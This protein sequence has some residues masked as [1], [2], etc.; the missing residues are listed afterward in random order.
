MASL[1]TTLRALRGQVLLLWRGGGPVN[2]RSLR[3][4]GEC[5]YGEISK[6]SIT[7]SASARASSM[8]MYRIGKPR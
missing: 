3:L 5:P 7:P 4:C 2:G 8:F 1:N 6:L